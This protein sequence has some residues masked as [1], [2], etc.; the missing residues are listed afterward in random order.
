MVLIYYKQNTHFVKSLGRKSFQ[1]DGL[2]CL[3]ISKPCFGD[4]Q[5]THHM[6]PSYVKTTSSEKDL[7]NVI[8]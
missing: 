5:R 4:V 6:T 7:A 8:A 2:H 1:N 3:Y